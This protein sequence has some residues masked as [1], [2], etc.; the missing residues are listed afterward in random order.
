MPL[1]VSKI[2]SL[3]QNKTVR[4]GGIFAVFSFVNQGINFILLFVL[5]WYISTE[6]Y[7][8][9]NLFYTGVAVVSILISLDTQGIIAV[10][11]FKKARKQL[12][13]Y[14][15]AILLITLIVSITLGICVS[16][17]NGAIF[18]IS[19]IELNYQLICV[20]IC[21]SSILYNLLTEIYRL[22]ERPFIYGWLTMSSTLLNLGG[23]LL[24]V[25]GLKYDWQGRVFANL[26]MSTCFIVI[27]L[28]ILTKKKYILKLTPSK[29]VLKE[30]L[31]FGVPLIPHHL[32]G[33]IRQGLDRFIINSNYSMAL[34][35]QFS[36][37]INFA[38]IISILGTA[39]NQ[40]NSVY[41]YQSLSNDSVEVRRKLRK[42][43]VMMLFL[44]LCLTGFTIALCYILIPI[45]LPAYKGS[46]K[47]VI[48]LCCSAYFQCVYLLF[49]NY[50][51]FF[52]KT[53][54][55]MYITFGTSLF[56]LG[57]SLCLTRYSVMWPA[58]ISLI[59]S[60]IQAVAVYFYSMKQY[61]LF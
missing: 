6:S 35:G 34:V 8:K 30:V 42:Q 40:S 57:L 17:F 43:T 56:H 19:S 29:D 16:A 27:S 55:L 12:A 18:R 52:K 11:Y 7:G 59:S 41:I 58:Y 31:T 2:Q 21:A 33:W 51:F 61:K 3:L 49:C 22:E 45:A 39:F 4:N 60:F 32:T 15:N 53:R 23:T 13:E 44:F 36:F 5:S 28:Y 24:F 50:L 1:F 10:N 48:P 14:V 54:Q 38:N 37:A 26:L 46:L 9:L 25:V 20:F 47:F